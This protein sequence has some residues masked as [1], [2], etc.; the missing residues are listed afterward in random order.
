MPLSYATV[1]PVQ[2]VENVRALVPTLRTRAQETERL[3]RLSPWI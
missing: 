2:I 3:R 1:D